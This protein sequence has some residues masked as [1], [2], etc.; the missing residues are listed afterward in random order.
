MLFSPFVSQQKKL[1]KP[2]WY[3]SHLKNLIKSLEFDEK[4]LDKIVCLFDIIC[5]LSV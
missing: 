3:D 5:E 4:N 2:T 1:V